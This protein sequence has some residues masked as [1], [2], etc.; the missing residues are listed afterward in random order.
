MGL[1]SAGWIPPVQEGEPKALLAVGPGVPEPDDQTVVA[2]SSGAVESDY[3]GAPHN[4]NP[5]EPV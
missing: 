4:G 3:G 5:S 2:C 1:V